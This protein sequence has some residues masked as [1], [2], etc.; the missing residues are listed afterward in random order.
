MSVVSFFQLLYFS[1]L[2]KITIVKSRKLQESINLQNSTIVK[3]ITL[4][5]MHEF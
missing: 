4:Q 5:E 1:N 3:S 2:Q